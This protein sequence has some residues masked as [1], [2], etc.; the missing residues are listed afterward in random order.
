MVQFVGKYEHVSSEGLEEYLN[1]IGG[2][3]QVEAAKAFAQSK[4]TLQVEEKGDEF[5]ITVM[6]EGKAAVSTF[7]LGVP[8]D[9]TMP[10]GAVLKVIL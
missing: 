1:A 7:K 10:H 2:A 8:Y 6:N 4:P 3:N 5:V 9:E